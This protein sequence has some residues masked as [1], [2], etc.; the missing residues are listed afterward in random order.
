MSPSPPEP[1]RWSKLYDTLFGRKALQQ[2]G[3]TG[4]PP[5]P[6]PTQP[7]TDISGV[8]QAAMDAAARMQKAKDANKGVAPKEFA[9]G[10]IVRYGGYGK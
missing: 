5:A 4:N 6:A 1:S 10:G 8:R 2:A 9:R 7:Q 3:Q